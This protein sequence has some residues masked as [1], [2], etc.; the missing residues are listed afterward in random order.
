MFGGR[1]KPLEEKEFPD[2]SDLDG[3][4]DAVVASVEPCPSC[5][6]LIYEQAQQCPHCRAW[7]V[8]SGQRWRR[9]RKW[10]VRGGLYLAKTLV[11]N[12]LFW[13]VLAAI[14]AVLVVWEMIR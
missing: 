11:L 13:L 5:G 8:R 1:D 4:D 7:V 10:Y 14:G 9:S 3:D 12:W 2:E 6:E